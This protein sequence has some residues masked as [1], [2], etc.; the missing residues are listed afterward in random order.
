MTIDA[1]I[2]I[3]GA[4]N[5]VDRF[6]DNVRTAH[7][8]G[9]GTYWTPQIFGMEALTAIAVAGREVP[10]IR[11]GTSVVPVQPRHAMMMA[12]Q[13]LTVSQATGGRFDLGIGLSH[14]VVVE[15]MWGLPFDKPYTYMREYLDA[16][17]PLVAGEGSSASGEYV[18]SRG[19]L[20]VRA[21]A[22][23]VLV[24]ALGPKMLKL[25]GERCDGTI[26]WMTGPKTIASHTAPVMNEAAAAAG[27]ATPQIVAGIPVCVTEDVD[28]GLKLA[29]EAYAI[30]GTLPSYQAMMEREGV[31][32]PA[33]I[34]I[35]GDADAVTER[36]AGLAEAGA[37]S[38]AA[39]EFGTPDDLAATR[40]LLV[41]LNSQA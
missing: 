36:L 28:A 35:V 6:V 22:P 1:K 16:L 23:P 32:G 40:E 11:F 2:D 9:F 20:E 15:S 39:S 29:A 10:D 41:S 8:Q 21:D 18:T 34:A 24:A 3:F 30:Y 31:D 26:T 37:T 27:R 4:D 38:I 12:Q 5:S 25:T 7:E 33:G 13:A 14:Q 17:M 19:A